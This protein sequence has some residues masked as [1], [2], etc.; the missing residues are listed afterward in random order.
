MHV[1]DMPVPET[2]AWV[3]YRMSSKNSAWSMEILILL[4]LRQIFGG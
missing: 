2:I 1:Q 3:E 4:E